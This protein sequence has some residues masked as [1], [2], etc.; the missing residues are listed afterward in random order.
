L[1]TLFGAF[2]LHRISPDHNSDFTGNTCS[3]KNCPGFQQ[4][5]ILKAGEGSAASTTHSWKLRGRI[6]GKSWH[7]ILIDAL[8]YNPKSLMGLSNKVKK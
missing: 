8:G 4:A 2:F 7:K 3:K 6:S 5:T 1:Q